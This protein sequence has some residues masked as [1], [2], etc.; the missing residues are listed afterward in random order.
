MKHHRPF[1]LCA[2]LATCTYLWADRKPATALAL[3]CS[4]QDPKTIPTARENARLRGA[5][6]HM[7]T[8]M[9]RDAQRGGWGEVENSPFK[10]LYIT[11]SSAL[12]VAP[13]PEMAKEAQ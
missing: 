6:T 13:I 7:L 5:L 8:T 10:S 11:A 2:A 1:L 12:G 9:R 3:E 4:S